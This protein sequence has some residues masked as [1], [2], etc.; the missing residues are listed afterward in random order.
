MH[1]DIIEFLKYHPEGVTSLDLANTFL[2]MTNAPQA[3]ADTT[4]QS[5]LGKDRRCQQDK[6]GIWRIRTT[7]DNNKDTLNELPFTGVFFITSPHNNGRKIFYFSLWDINPEPRYKWGVWLTDPNILPDNEQELMLKGPDYPYNPDNLK[8]F[9]IRAANDLEKSIPV[10]LT[11]Y[12]QNIL[13][14][15]CMNSGICL[16]DDSIFIS[17]FLKAAQ[18]TIPRPINVLTLQKTVFDMDTIPFNPFKQG[19]I[20]AGCVSELISL[21]RERGITGRQEMEK[22]LVKD[23]NN[24]FRDKAYNY[25]SISSLP[26]APG[27]YGFQN[28][29]GKYIYIGKAK[30]LRR[31][32]CGYFR[33]TDESPEKLCQLH[34][35]AYSLT[36]VQCG[37]EL[38]SL[39]LEYRLI[40]KHLPYLNSKQV[41]HERKG[42]FLPVDDCIIL[43]PHT[44][45]ECVMSFWLR[46][47]QKIQMKKLNAILEYDTKLIEE[48][49]NFFFSKKTPASDQDFPEQEI[50]SRWIKAHKDFLI[51]VPVNRMK[52]SQE[53]W[54][55]LPNY[56]QEV[57]LT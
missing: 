10:F 4:I 38:E 15:L 3:L 20:F 42:R 24:Y 44:E 9:I 40:R 46:K 11:S 39:I 19:E 13:R 45:Q 54:E 49:E 16:T 23:N 29:S 17:E 5:I 57:N 50:A 43:L 47:N 28:R 6:A 12:H 8:T 55:A 2:K 14:S 35:D 37:S 51:T 21:L 26:K 56:I 1:D 48:L 41:I 22:S 53:I 25:T 36:T 7:T 34:T 27:V 52:D 31:R 18:L 33:E 32:V 30:N